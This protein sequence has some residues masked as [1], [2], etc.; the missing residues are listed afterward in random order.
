MIPP[1]FG[2][3][4]DLV[5]DLATLAAT[6]RPSRAQAQLLAMIGRFDAALDLIAA[7]ALVPAAN[8][9]APD[10]RQQEEPT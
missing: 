9:D 7:L 5:T 3:L 2:L 8:A 10:T 1:Y 6:M 4:C